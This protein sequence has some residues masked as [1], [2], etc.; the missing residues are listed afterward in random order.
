[1]VARG[2]G[3]SSVAP[4]RHRRVT[5]W[6]A[7]LRVLVAVLGLAFF[8]GC[9]PAGTVRPGGTEY[10][11]ASVDVEGVD[12]VD[13]AALLE[14][15]A[16]Q[17]N[18]LNPFTPTSTFNRY[19]VAEDQERIRTF[20]AARGYFDAEVVDYDVRLDEGRHRRAHVT[21]YV[22][23]GAQSSLATDAVYDTSALRAVDVGSLI[24]ATPLRA[25]RPF[26]QA[27]V[28]AE[29]ERLRRTLQERSFARA[30]I[31][32]RVYVDRE[33][34]TARVYFFIDPG[35]AC[36]F[37]EIRVVGNAHVPAELIRETTG[38][39]TGRVYQQSR[40]RDAQV[41]L[42]ALDAFTSVEVTPE[43]ST[44][45]A[46]PADPAGAA[47]TDAL[48]AADGFELAI[49]LS[50]PAPGRPL[51][52]GLLDNIDQIESYDPY[53]PV[54]VTVT[55]SPAAA[56]KTGGGLAIES[57]RTEA[58][59]RANATWRNVL[60]PLNRAELEG[61]LGYAWLPSVFDRNTVADGLIGEVSGGLT[62]PRLVLGIFDATLRLGFEHGI[63]PDHAFS[64]PSVRL[65]LE[66]RVGALTRVNFGYA[67]EINLTRDFA[68][69]VAVATARGSC[70]ELPRAF[71]IG[72]LD[73]GVSR[74]RS[75]FDPRE[76]L[77]RSVR[78]RQTNDDWAGSLRAQ[79]GEGVLGDYPYLRIE[80][81]LRYYRRL[82]SRLTVA[83]RASV[84]A[85]VDFG[86]P[87]P[88]SQCLFLGGGSTIRGFAERRAGPHA[89]ANIPGGGVFSALFNF[90]PR[91]ALSDLFGL[92][93]FVDL[94]EVNTRLG[95]DA[96]WGG[97]T[98]A[99]AAVGGGLRIF[100]PIGPV[101]A[102][103]GVR[104]T[105]LP[106]DFGRSRPVQFVFSLGEAF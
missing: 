106:S 83:T 47:A 40:L 23:E 59:G 65:G 98:G 103:I 90:E 29:R 85:I 1:M 61:R 84:G 60:A 22:E 89:E 13:R 44:A 21:F 48:Q 92:V 15:L 18:T 69:D 38:I 17:E 6:C 62:R 11:V 32:A 68:D 66:N 73:A 52:A 14:V 7:R 28:E 94:G 4:G 56:Y 87:V 39:R 80:P 57:S 96:A 30:R 79:L 36:V 72:Y 51:A 81:D 25:G 42:Y 97:A 102:D 27:E 64:R 74:D 70:D 37:G 34:H 95:L 45:P 8:S 26:S 76:R 5:Q 46:R 43:L 101:R 77:R 100:T 93:A 41:E 63:E 105:P 3:P 10:R 67:F 20:Y 58:Y 91:L 2:R 88:R 104:V 9:R 35:I 78:Y 75:N 99:H 24:G 19:E 49:R 33:A 50:D 55:E 54:I 82:G 12:A 86:E 16:T 31:D 53:V 71:R